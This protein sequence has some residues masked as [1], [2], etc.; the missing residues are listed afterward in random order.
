[1]I[2]DVRARLRERIK[3]GATFDEIET[4]IRMSRGLRQQERWQL[5]SWAWNY[6]PDAEKRRSRRHG[7][8]R[9]AIRRGPGSGLR[10]RLH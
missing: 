1:M 6:D 10:P 9:N 7:S 5:W 2:E 3:R 8:V 4:V